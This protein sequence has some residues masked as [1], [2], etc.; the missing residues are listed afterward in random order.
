MVLLSSPGKGNPHLFDIQP[1]WKVH[2]AAG[3]SPRIAHRD[4]GGLGALSS[5][6]SFANE[7]A[8]EECSCFLH[9]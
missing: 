2:F 4:N 7:Q 3:C 6:R 5:I 1:P 9:C 8:S